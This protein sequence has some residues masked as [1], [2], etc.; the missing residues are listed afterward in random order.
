MFWRSIVVL[1]KRMLSIHQGWMITS[2]ESGSVN[3]IIQLFTVEYCCVRYTTLLNNLK[4]IN[5]PF[6]IPSPDTH[7]TTF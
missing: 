3:A 2:R 4:V 5:Y 7:N 6:E 1:Q